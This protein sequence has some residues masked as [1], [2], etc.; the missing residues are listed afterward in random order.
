MEEKCEK[1]SLVFALF[2]EAVKHKACGV[3]KFLLSEREA[4]SLIKRLIV[5]KMSFIKMKLYINWNERTFYT[6]NTLDEV[7]SDCPYLISEA[8]ETMIQDYTIRDIISI[9][10]EDAQKKLDEYIDD[11]IADFIDAEFD[12]YDI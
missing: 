4:Y 7:L 11:R 1:I 10:S 5:F 3:N 8:E 6:E 12:E 9:G 2:A